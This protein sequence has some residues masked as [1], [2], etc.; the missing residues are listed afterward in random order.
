MGH[1]DIALRN[2]ERGSG[3]SV[4][5]PRSARIKASQTLM[6]ESLS[7]SCREA[8]AASRHWKACL[9]SKPHNQMCVSRSRPT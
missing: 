7:S 8:S 3:S 9:E 2:Q 5:R 1:F 6:G 4:N